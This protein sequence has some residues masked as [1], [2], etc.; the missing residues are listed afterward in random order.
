MKNIRLYFVRGSM[1]I[2]ISP[3]KPAV[4]KRSYDNS[5]KVRLRGQ[6]FRDS[7]TFEEKKIFVLPIQDGKLIQQV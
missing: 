6:P 4:N 3:D 5:F 7:G 2:M 1:K